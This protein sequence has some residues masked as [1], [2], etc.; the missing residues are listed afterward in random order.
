LASAIM[1]ELPG[2]GA[3]TGHDSSTAGLIAH[4]K[5]LR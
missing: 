1:P 5:A 2:P 4:Y 3:A